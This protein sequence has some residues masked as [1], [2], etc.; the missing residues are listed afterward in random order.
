MKIREVG[1]VDREALLD[2]L[3]SKCFP[4]LE[5]YPKQG[6]YWW[7]AEDRLGVCAFA[8]LKFCGHHTGFLCRVGVEKDY[9][10]QGLHKKLIRVREAKARKLGWKW[11]IT[12]CSYYN[13][14]SANNLLAC[15][16]KL[17]SPQNPYGVTGALYFR[18][19]L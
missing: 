11:L 16:Y 17:Y 14:K 10:G 15:G 4:G 3:D 19:A 8:G 12:Y 9:R 6:A 18:K 2:Q 13:L 5:P 7:I 1:S